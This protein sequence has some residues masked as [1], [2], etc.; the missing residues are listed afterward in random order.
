ME[1]KTD[2]SPKVPLFIMLK[3][4][5]FKPLFIFGGTSNFAGQWWFWVIL[6]AVIIFVVYSGL[7]KNRQEK[8]QRKQR[9]KEV[10]Q[11]LK[12]HLAK[13][14]KFQNVSLSYV[15]VVAR[16]GKRYTKRDVFDV[17]V[18]ITNPR[19][20]LSEPV[21]KCFEIEGTARYTDPKDKKSPVLI[22]WKV[23]GEFDY[24]NHQQLL[25]TRPRSKV[26]IYLSS[27][28][29][30]KKRQSYLKTELAKA[31]TLRQGRKQIDEKSER[32][33]ATKVAREEVFKPEPPR[34]PA[35]E[36]L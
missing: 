9:E 23:N 21:Y 19:A 8:K 32:I 4:L 27:L 14:S 34:K 1:Q 7:K 11:L 28:F 29:Q 13:T 15:D 35:D 18:K 24:Q 2:F 33:I 26:G 30:G 3:I 20:K 6:A 31:Q 16:T 17:F 10:K 5:N 22:D 25:K 12:K 36:N